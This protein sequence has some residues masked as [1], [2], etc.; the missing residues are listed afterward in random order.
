[1]SAA[2]LRGREKEK[3]YIVVSVRVDRARVE[4]MLV[5]V[6]DELENISVVRSGD[7]EIVDN[8]DCSKFSRVSSD[9]R[10]GRKGGEAHDE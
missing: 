8:R 6:I 1:M 2:T 5:E 4:E 7:A 10:F 9:S 3:T